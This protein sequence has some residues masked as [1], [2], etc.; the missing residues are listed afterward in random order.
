MIIDRLFYCTE[1]ERLYTLA[2]MEQFRRESIAS[3][4]TFATGNINDYINACL[5]SNNGTI[6]EVKREA[7]VYDHGKPVL[8]IWNVKTDLF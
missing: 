3:G 5:A 2:D 7:V 8:T 6:V 4:D 1:T